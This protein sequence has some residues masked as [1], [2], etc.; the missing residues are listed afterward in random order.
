MLKS[1]TVIVLVFISS[2][3]SVLFCFIYSDALMLVP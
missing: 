3:T 2:L 1:L